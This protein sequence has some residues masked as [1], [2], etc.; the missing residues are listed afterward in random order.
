VHLQAHPSRCFG[1]H[2]A[3]DSIFS[4]QTLQEPSNWEDKL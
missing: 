1:S 3:T 2:H 4:E